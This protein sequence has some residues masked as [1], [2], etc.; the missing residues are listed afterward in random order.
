MKKNLIVL[1]LGVS[2]FL[3]SIAMITSPLRNV[4]NYHLK[5]AD[6]IS[7]TV[8]RKSNYQESANSRK[9]EFEYSYYKI[10][11][12]FKDK[13]FGFNTSRTIEH[14]I[15]KS[16]FETLKIGDKVD[17]SDLG[18]TSRADERPNTLLASTIDSSIFQKFFISI[19]GDISEHVFGVIL[20]IIGGITTLISI[21]FIFKKRRINS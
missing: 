6:R 16:E 5:H 1:A 3:L 12:N 10:R 14:L 11:V 4:A 18:K 20:L 17:V 15:R 21:V 9:G 2:I 7:A 8:E 19:K 13:N